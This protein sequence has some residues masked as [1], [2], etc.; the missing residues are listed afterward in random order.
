[1]NQNELINMNWNGVELN[2]RDE[3]ELNQRTRRRM[4]PS[5]L[6]QSK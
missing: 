4:R 1:M 5:V 2:E 3:N 6:M